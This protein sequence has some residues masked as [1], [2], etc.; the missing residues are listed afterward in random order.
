MNFF[1]SQLGFSKLLKFFLEYFGYIQDAVSNKLGWF[2][3]AIASILEQTIPPHQIV[4]VKDG[5][6]DTDLDHYIKNIIK[7]DY[8]VEFTLYETKINMGRGNTLNTA[9]NLSKYDFVSIMDSDDIARLDKLLA[10]PC[11]SSRSFFI[12]MDL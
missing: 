7:S 8:G 12:S 9:L 5:P 3:E 11:L 10:T 6:V 2:K 1:G 4:I